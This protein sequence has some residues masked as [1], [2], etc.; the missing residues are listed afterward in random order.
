MCDLDTSHL[1]T[2]YFKAAY[3]VSKSNYPIAKLHLA[4]L[5]IPG[6]LK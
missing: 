4:E 3:I 5:A 2:S 1:G 6:N